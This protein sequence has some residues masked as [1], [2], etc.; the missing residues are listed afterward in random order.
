MYLMELY[1]ESGTVVLVV[2][3]NY[4]RETRRKELT[5]ASYIYKQ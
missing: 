1:L 2:L 5:A 3:W 4:N